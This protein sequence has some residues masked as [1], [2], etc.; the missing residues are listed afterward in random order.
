MIEYFA[1]SSRMEMRF[2][3]AAEEAVDSVQGTVIVTVKAVE[4]RRR[5]N[6]RR[7]MHKTNGHGLYNIF[8]YLDI[9]IL[10]CTSHHIQRV[11]VSLF[12]PGSDG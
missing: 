7:A 8:I 9:S 3:N 10:G 11:F 1:T 12:R 4:L 2:G 5:H 6:R